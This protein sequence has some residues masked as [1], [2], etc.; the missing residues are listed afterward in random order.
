MAVNLKRRS[1]VLLL[2]APTRDDCAHRCFEND[3]GAVRFL[4]SRALLPIEIPSEP[5][6]IF[7]RGIRVPV[8]DASAVSVRRGG[9]RAAA[10]RSNEEESGDPSSSPSSRRPA[11]LPSAQCAARGLPALSGRSSLRPE[12]AVAEALAFVCHGRRAAAVAWCARRAWE[13][14]KNKEEEEHL[15]PEHYQE[16]ANTHKAKEKKK[17]KAKQLFAESST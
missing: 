13:L 2:V 9:L 17:Q 10:S 8:T 14:E 7:W 11:S 6:L 16:E 15:V 3:R 5:G 4:G 1:G 12:F